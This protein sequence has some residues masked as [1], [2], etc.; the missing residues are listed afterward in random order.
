MEILITEDGFQ[1][2]DFLGAVL[3][4]KFKVSVIKAK[5]GGQAISLIK[6]HQPD[7]LIL[8]MTMP[9]KTGFDV[10]KEIESNNYTFPVLVISGYYF[11]KEEVVNTAGVNGE[12]IYFLKKPFTSEEIIEEIKKII[13]VPEKK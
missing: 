13:I 4:R 11:S 6:N 3:N 1:T 12:H 2:R 8:D 10:L 5:D 7:L 9:V